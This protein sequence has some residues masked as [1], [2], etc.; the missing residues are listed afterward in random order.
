M[1]GTT[2]SDFLETDCRFTF[3]GQTFE[4]SGAYVAPDSLV[5]YPGA[6]GVLTDWRG[7]PIGRWYASSSW[8]V[9]SWQGPRMYAIRAEVNGRHY[10]G[11]GF[12]EGMILRA[13]RVASELRAERAPDGN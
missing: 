10:Y 5:A 8:Q 2:M 12:G 3:Q 13:R 1:V 11:R 9:H 6:D 7:R 4:A